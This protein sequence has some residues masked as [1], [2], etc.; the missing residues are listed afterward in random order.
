MGNYLGRHLLRIFYSLLPASLQV[1]KHPTL[2]NAA[3]QNTG[4][5]G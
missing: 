4:K 2:A 5:V 3:G 1:S